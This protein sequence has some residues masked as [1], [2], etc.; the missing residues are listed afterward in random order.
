MHLKHIH[1]HNKL[2]K[3]TADKKKREMEVTQ[4]QTLENYLTRV[5]E[6]VEQLQT[7]RGN[8]RPH[9]II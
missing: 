4:S 6:E 9:R 8:Y 1:V 3:E 5:Q 7:V 2:L